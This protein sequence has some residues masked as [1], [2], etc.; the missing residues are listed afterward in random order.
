MSSDTKYS[1]AQIVVTPMP[2]KVRNRKKKPRNDSESGPET[3][4]ESGE[5]GTDSE[6]DENETE[7]KSEIGEHEIEN[8]RE[9]ESEKG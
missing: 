9:S 2:G 5:S 8:E 3:E 4:G 1:K 6:N 7:N